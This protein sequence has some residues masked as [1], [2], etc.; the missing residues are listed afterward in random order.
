MTYNRATKGNK[1]GIEATKRAMDRPKQKILMMKP[2][3]IK[4]LK[5]ISFST[6][7]SESEIVREILNKHL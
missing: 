7:K 1:E 6:G 2:S 4:K 3:M 5:E